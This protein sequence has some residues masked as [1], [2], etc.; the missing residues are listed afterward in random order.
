[1][2][3]FLAFLCVLALLL[4]S[5]VS[6][7]AAENVVENDTKQKTL[8]LKRGQTVDAWVFPFQTTKSVYL[9][10]IGDDQIVVKQVKLSGAKGNV[11]VTGSNNWLKATVISGNK[12]ILKVSGKNNTT[13]DKVCFLKVKDSRGEFGTIKIVRGGVIKINS[14]KQIGAKIQLTLSGASNYF[15]QIFCR[16]VIFD[17]QGSVL[18]ENYV[19]IMQKRTFVDESLQ[20]EK[21]YTVAYAVGYFHPGINGSW[22]CYA[23]AVYIKK[24]SGK[25]TGKT[26]SCV[27]DDQLSYNS[28][29]LYSIVH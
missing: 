23:A 17:A 19:N 3:K 7:A 26:K 28:E 18:S 16:R 25:A 1:M 9:P 22:G 5:M 15:D 12:I 14:I 20:L 10:D 29:W 24:A 6:L 4:T 2:K 27:D 8:T 11:T 13:K 21:G